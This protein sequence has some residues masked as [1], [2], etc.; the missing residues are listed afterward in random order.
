[1]QHVAWK[2]VREPRRIDF[3]A[4][5]GMAEMMEMHADLMCAAAVESAF[6]ETRLLVRT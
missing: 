1:M 4:Q 6:K 3:I 2:I 5:H